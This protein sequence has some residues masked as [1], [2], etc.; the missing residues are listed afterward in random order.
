M[1]QKLDKYKHLLGY[2]VLVAAI[3]FLFAQV[4]SQ[5]MQLNLSVRSQ[6]HNRVHNVAEWCNG[7]NQTRAYERALAARAVVIRTKGTIPL[8]VNNLDCTAI[9]KGTLASS[10]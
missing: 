8:V 7:I 9:E 6:L 2:L 4:H 3:A 5:Q 1:M 10:K